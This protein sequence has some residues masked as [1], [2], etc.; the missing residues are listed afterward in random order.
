MAARQASNAWRA[1]GRRGG[2][3]DRDL[4]DAQRADAV[5]DG[6]ATPGHSRSISSAISAS[7]FSAIS[8]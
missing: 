6:D 8:T 7:T 1:V 2:D 3:H 4:A 5:V